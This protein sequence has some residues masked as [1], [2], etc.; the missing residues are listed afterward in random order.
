MTNGTKPRGFRFDWPPQD[1]PKNSVFRRKMRSCFT[2]TYNAKYEHKRER[3][4]GCPHC[5]AVE[6]TIDGPEGG[7][8]VHMYCYFCNTTFLG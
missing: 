6:A 8:F 3:N 2:L 5:M 4:G 1:N 7:G